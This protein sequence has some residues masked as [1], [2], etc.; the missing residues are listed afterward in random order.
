MRTQYAWWSWMCRWKIEI[1]KIL[2]IFEMKNGSSRGLPDVFLIN[3]IRFLCD[4]NRS[5]G[6]RIDFSK[7][8]SKMMQKWPQKWS[9]S[10][11]CRGPTEKS[12]SPSDSSW[13]ETKSRVKLLFLEPFLMGKSLVQR[14]KKSL[15]G[16]PP[17]FAR[18]APWHQV[19][20]ECFAPKKPYLGALS[21]PWEWGAKHSPPSLAMKN[22]SIEIRKKRR[23]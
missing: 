12:R 3:N 19:G 9:C 6:C 11:R 20:G 1:S 4:L 2:K 16:G 10:N 15:T 7:I 8:S 22:Y 18:R 23:K 13:F 5:G 17:D 14:P 21:L